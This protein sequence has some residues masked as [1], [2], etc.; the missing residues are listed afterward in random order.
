M[1]NFEVVNIVEKF[2]NSSQNSGSNY[3]AKTSNSSIARLL[4]EEARYRWFG[5]I[6]EDDVMI[7]DIS[8]II[9]EL[10]SFE[11][12]KDNKTDTS[13]DERKVNKFKSIAIDE[14]VT[15]GS[16]NAVRKD[17]ARGSMAS[18]E[19]AIQEALLELHNEDKT[20]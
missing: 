19:A 1:E 17:P 7:D 10:N 16:K 5:T 11:N 6:E 13:S 18:D 15:I 4:C 14:I 12:G 9:L 20:Q 8:C 2:R 3:P